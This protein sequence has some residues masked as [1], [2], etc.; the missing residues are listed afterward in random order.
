M[1]EDADMRSFR[2]ECHVRDVCYVGNSANAALNEG[3]EE[4]VE[5][6]TTI[7]MTEPAACVRLGVCG[8]FGSS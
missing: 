7:M 5:E 3:E 8:G 2:G 1:Y 6:A 4:E